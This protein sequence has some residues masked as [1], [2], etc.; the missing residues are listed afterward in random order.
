MCRPFLLSCPNSVWACRCGRNS[1]SGG[2]GVGVLAHL[3]SQA[4]RKTPPPAKQSFAPKGVPKQSLGTRVTRV[5]KGANAEGNRASRNNGSGTLR[6][7]E[8]ASSA[9]KVRLQ[10]SPRQRPGKA[11]QSRSS[12]KRAEQRMCRPFRAGKLLPPTQGVALGWLVAGPL[13]LHGRER[14]DCMT[15]S[16]G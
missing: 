4:A 3:R 14:Q 6:S 7:E 13:A 5:E 15:G 12:P 1:V 2:R 9:P 10:T 16:S 11:I 8:A